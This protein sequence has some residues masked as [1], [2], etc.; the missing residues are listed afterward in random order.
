[1]FLYKQWEEFCSCL[2][3]NGIHSITARDAL[4]TK[5]IAHFLIL[6]HD[7][8]TNP[9][10]ALKMARI[11]HRHKQ[12]GSYYV[13][14]YLLDAPDNIRI[15][16]QI[17]EL[18]HEVSYH[19]DVMDSNKGDIT[20]AEREFECN[21]KR[22]EAHGFSIAT[23]CQ[24][25]NPI[26]DRIGYHSNRDF[27]RNAEVATKYAH[28]TEIMVHFRARIQADCLYISDAGYR[29]NIISNPE[30]NDVENCMENDV[31]LESLREIVELGMRQSLIVST[32]PHRWHNNLITMK[33][34]TLMFHLLKSCARKIVRF[35]AIKRILVKHY[36]FAKKI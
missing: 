4:Q 28:I 21:K 25:G 36:A 27:F 35:S 14:A 32:H 34:Q 20:N 19:H 13:Q 31:T 9:K 3:G 7:V 33:I 5:G 24:H 11:E 1:M 17:G 16:K 8:E 15:L 6:K 30:S 10:K 22:F 29:W 12:Q 18:G 23:V 26:I 2:E